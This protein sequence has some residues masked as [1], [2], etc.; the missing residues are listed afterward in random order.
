MKTLENDERQAGIWEEFPLERVLE[1]LVKTKSIRS[2]K[3]LNVSMSI[4][5][6][7]FI[8]ENLFLE[9]T[10]HPHAF[11]SEFYQTIK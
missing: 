5:K 1:H 6:I 8:T 7:K 2:L 3:T 9:K 10:Y 11:I 4:K